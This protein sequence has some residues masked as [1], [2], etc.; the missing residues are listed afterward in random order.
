MSAYIN[1]H[2]GKRKEAHRLAEQ[3][4]LKE[5]WADPS[6]FSTIFLP[7]S[8]HEPSVRGV[9]RKT[10]GKMSDTGGGKKK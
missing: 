2:L 9:E 5:A 4:P 6:V 3:Q 8:Y 7:H 10:I 1:V